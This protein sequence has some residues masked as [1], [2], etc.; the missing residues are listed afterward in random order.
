MPSLSIPQGVSFMEATV[1]TVTING[2]E[3][4]SRDSLA[5]LDPQPTSN[6]QI[7]ILQRGW[8]MV[9]RFRQDG[10]QCTLDNTSVIRTWGTS[11]GLGQ[12]ALEGPTSSTK[13]DPVGHVEFHELTMVAR[14]NTA[15]S[16]WKL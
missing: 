11:K 12:L 8:V 5:A 6:I 13:L 10:Q 3:Y 4:V 1:D 2:K 9:G 16:L 7:V 15:E 14:I